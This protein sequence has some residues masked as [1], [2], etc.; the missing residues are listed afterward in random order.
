MRGL[1]LDQ[2]IRCKCA[3]FRYFEKHEHHVTRFCKDNV[4]LLVFDGTLRF[5]ENGEQVEVRG[6][7]YY[8]QQ[9]NGYQGGELASDA[10]SYF[11]VHFDAE[12]KMND[13]LLPYRGGFDHSLLSNVMERLDRASHAGELQI[14]QQYLFLKILMALREQKK[15]G[16]V[17]REIADYMA[18]NLKTISSL[19]ELCAEFHYSKNYIIRLFNDEFGVTPIQYLNSLKIK[20]SMY[21]LES[22]SMPVL[23]I[24]EECGYSDYTNFYKRFIQKTGNSPLKWRETVHNNPASRA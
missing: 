10:P 23:K 8:I 2:A 21:L 1:D 14:E 12:W 3:S 20:Q 18:Q 5:S 9:K 7:E 17:A 13:S 19:S 4:L 6:G 16:G 24:A 22:T 15:Q 11:Y